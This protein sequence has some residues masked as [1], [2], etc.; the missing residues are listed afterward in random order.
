MPISPN[1]YA[2]RAYEFE[3]LAETAINPAVKKQYLDLA[4]ELRTLA[5]EWAMFDSQPS[6]EEVEHLVE[7]MIGGSPSKL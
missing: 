6:D 4:T 3:Q 1:D 7:R 5:K 2:K